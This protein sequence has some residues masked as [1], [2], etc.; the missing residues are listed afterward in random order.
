MLTAAWV[1]EVVARVWFAPI[2]QYSYEPLFRNLLFDEVLGQVSQ[3]KPVQDGTACELQAVDSNLPLDAHVDFASALLEL[4]GKIPTSRDPSQVDAAV[5]GEVFRTLWHRMRL[6]VVRRSD[7]RLP[8]FRTD[9]HR[10]HIL[11]DELAHPDTG[12]ETC[13]HDVGEALVSHEFDCDVG[14]LAHQL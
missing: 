8:H 3:P 9:A 13:A 5:I 14:I 7:D 11:L 1:I 6:E 10:D 12:I 4:P 2:F